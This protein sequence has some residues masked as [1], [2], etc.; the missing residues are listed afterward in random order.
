ML[1]CR[2]IDSDAFMPMTYIHYLMCIHTLH[3]THR[4]IYITSCA[5]I[6]YM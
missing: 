1:L 4:L 6:H 3:V 5:Y 2:L